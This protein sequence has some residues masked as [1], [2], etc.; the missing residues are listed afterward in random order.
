M[1]RA[2]KAGEKLVVEVGRGMNWWC[3][4]L[5]SGKLKCGLG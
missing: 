4:L 2:K 1:S 3:G 5:L